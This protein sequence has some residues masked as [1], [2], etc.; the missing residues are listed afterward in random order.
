MD[1]NEQIVKLQ[2]MIHSYLFNQEK[3][4]L[5]GVDLMV[6]LH[7]HKPEFCFLSGDATPAYNHRGRYTLCKEDQVLTPSVFNA[8]NTVLIDK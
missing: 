1:K 4:S 2:G 6:K 8:I 7:C 5:N 3:L